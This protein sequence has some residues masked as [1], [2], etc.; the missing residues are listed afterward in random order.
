MR[1]KEV[2]KPKES[3][4]K[5]SATEHDKLKTNISSIRESIDVGVL[6]NVGRGKEI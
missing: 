4:A 3:N 2:Q 6:A 1:V 5:T